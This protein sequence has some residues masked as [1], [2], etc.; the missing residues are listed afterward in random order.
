MPAFDPLRNQ[1]YID[2]VTYRRSGTPVHTPVWFAEHDGRLYVMTRSDSGKAKRI[3]N[4]RRV[5][6]APCTMR[7]KR[8]GPGIGATARV[9][10]DPGFARSLIRKKYL[11]ARLPVWSKQNIYIEIRP[12]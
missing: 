6:V 1:S 9:A 8:T 2:L 3:R 11:L 7:G 4:N 10:S 5:E 12:E